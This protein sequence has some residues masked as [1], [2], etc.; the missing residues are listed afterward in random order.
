MSRAHTGSSLLLI[1]VMV[2]GTTLAADGGDLQILTFP[3]G[4]VTGELPVETDLAEID[5]CQKGV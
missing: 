1:S 5:R 2:C 4:L 3:I